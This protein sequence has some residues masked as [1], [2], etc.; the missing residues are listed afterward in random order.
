MTIPVADNWQIVVNVNKSIQQIQ[1][2]KE[3]KRNK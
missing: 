2:T 3:V 1:E